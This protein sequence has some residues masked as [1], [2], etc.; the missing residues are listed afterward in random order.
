[1]KNNIIHFTIALILV[2]VLHFILGM[3]T[4]TINH[5]FGSSSCEVFTFEHVI[6]FCIPSWKILAFVS[7]GFL[8]GVIV[9]FTMKRLSAFTF[10]NFFDKKWFKKSTNMLFYLWCVYLLFMIAAITYFAVTKD[11]CS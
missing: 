10:F 11:I 1:M 9:E 2:F 3:S 4:L 7:I 8:I 5:I 6:K